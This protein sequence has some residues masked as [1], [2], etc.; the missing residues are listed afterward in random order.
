MGLQAGADGRGGAAAQAVVLGG[1]HLQELA[2]AQQQGLE[3][4]GGL[5][6]QR[7]RLGADALGEQGQGVGVQGIGLGQPAAGLG[8]VVDLARVDDRDVMAGAGQGGGGMFQAAGGL[9]DD[10]GGPQGL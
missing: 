8:E 7:P 9:Q 6:G 2:A 3:V 10:V 4:A 5:V 1:A